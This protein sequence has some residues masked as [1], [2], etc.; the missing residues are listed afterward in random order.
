MGIEWG[1]WVQL[2]PGARS[3]DQWGDVRGVQQVVDAELD[4]KGV[5][6]GAHGIAG[7]KGQLC[8]SNV[9]DEGEVR[10]SEEKL[11]G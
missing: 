10:L 11:R 9:T 2:P 4:D 1:A 5:Q 7:I 8:Q 6:R 3:S